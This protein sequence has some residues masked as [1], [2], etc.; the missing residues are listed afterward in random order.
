M[1]KLPCVSQVHNHQ[2][3]LHILLTSIFHSL[4]TIWPQLSP[5]ATIMAAKELPTIL[6]IPGAFTLPPCYDRLLPYLQV[7]STVVANLP[8]CNA[9]DPSSASCS[10]DGAYIREQF[11]LPICEEGRSVVLFA[12]S[13]GGLAGEIAALGLSKSRR[14]AEGKSGG[15][16]GLIYL[17]GNIVPENGSLFQVVGG[18]W[19]PYIKTD[20]VCTPYPP[21]HSTLLLFA[22]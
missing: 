7:Y 13:Y 8:S 11:L 5:S 15:V 2:S 21:S 22:Y 4:T 19:P 3:S 16:V 12:H 20:T 14:I 10:K 18:A 1:F 6:L 17:S 9:A